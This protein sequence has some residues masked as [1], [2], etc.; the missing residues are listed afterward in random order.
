MA[1]YSMTFQR[2]DFRQ[3]RRWRHGGQSGIAVEHHGRRRPMPGRHR[4]VRLASATPA[5]VVRP[6]ERNW[7]SC[8]RRCPRWC[9]DRAL[10]DRY[11]YSPITLPKTANCGWPGTGPSNRPAGSAFRTFT[12]AGYSAFRR[13]SKEFP[14]C[15]GSSSPPCGAGK[16]ATGS[17]PPSAVVVV[18]AFWRCP[19]SQ[20]PGQ[21]P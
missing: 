6:F 16:N 1:Y 12:N 20:R 10:Q 11:R 2:R 4:V 15:H 8:R 14:H 9:R 13:L 19:L 3:P 18:T 7:A 5:R 17:V 21:W